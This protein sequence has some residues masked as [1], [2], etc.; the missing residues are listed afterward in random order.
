MSGR[1]EL[2]LGLRDEYP[3][4]T[5]CV[6]APAPASTGNIDP[7]S[8]SSETD[9]VSGQTGSNHGRTGTQTTA[10]SSGQ[11]DRSP[12]LSHG[13]GGFSLLWKLWDVE[14]FRHVQSAGAEDQY[15]LS[16]YFRR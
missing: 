5:G 3:G 6:I 10:S 7:K 12:D 1:R 2:Q 11:S 13:P 9:L 15:K 16:G 8:E 4:I 14:R